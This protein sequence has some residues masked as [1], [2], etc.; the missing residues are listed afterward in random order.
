[1]N[2]SKYLL[3]VQSIRRRPHY[4]HAEQAH[5]KMI[6][7]TNDAVTRW[8]LPRPQLR[9][10]PIVLS[11]VRILATPSRGG[12]GGP[13]IS[14]GIEPMRNAPPVSL[15]NITGQRARQKRPL[16]P[17]VTRPG[18]S[19]MRKER[20]RVGFGVPHRISVQTGG[21]TPAPHWSYRSPRRPMYQVY[22]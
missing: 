7:R 11:P 1:V 9:R 10:I 22:G 3:D 12:L 13:D 8:E 19:E 6:W 21:N 2:T 14:A 17:H 20:L 16:L 4:A 18:I 5:R 15:G